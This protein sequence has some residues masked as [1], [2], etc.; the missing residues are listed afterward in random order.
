MVEFAASLP[1]PE[2]ADR[3]KAARPAT[4]SALF[5]FATNIQRHFEELPSFP[6]GLLPI[7]DT[8]GS[9]NPIYGTGM[10]SALLQ[11][12]ALQSAL[13]G[14]A[15]LDQSLDGLGP[16]LLAEFANIVSVFWHRAAVG[17]FF[18]SETSGDRPND[19][20]EVRRFNAAL[21]KLAAQDPEVQRINLRVQHS[22]DP[23]AVLETSGVR[24][25]V[26]AILAS[27]TEQER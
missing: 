18:F 5:N 12:K 11:A 1:A 2:I 3:M 24:G 23:P 25:R 8:I 16:Q 21:A 19:L 20:D 27:E 13:R 26:L 14:R 7:G 15:E 6:E 4:E 22:L 10:T 17:D 9:M